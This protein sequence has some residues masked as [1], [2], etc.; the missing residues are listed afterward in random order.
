MKA[1]LYDLLQVSMSDPESPNILLTVRLS[2]LHQLMVD[3]IEAT[4]ERLLP[5]FLEAE[6]DKPLTKKQAAEQLGVC[7]TTIWNMVQSGKLHP[8]KVHGSTRYSQR[9]IREI[10]NARNND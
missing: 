6:K 2:D 4:R 10:I 7:E 8:F 5:I 1:S 3:T 9:E